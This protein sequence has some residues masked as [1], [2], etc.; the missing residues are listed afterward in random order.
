MYLSDYELRGCLGCN[1]CQK[2]LNEIGCVQKD[3]IS[4]IIYKIFNAD[5]VFFATPLYG[6]SYSGQLKLLMDR[7]VCLFK[8]I[9]GSDKAVEEMEIYSLIDSKPVGLIVT[10][11]GPEENNTELIKIQFDKF[12][13][14]SLAKCI[15]KYIFPFWNDNSD[16]TYFKEETINKLIDDICNEI[17]GK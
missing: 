8:F 15:G 9:S 4:K 1:H 6:H 11:Q 14:S 17:I 12:C 10:C 3:D 13:E 5:I 7:Q 16:L 2:V